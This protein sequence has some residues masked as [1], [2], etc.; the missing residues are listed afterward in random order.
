MQ[1]TLLLTLSLFPC[2]LLSCVVPVTASAQR[3][4]DKNVPLRILK[5]KDTLN[6]IAYKTTV[7]EHIKELETPAVIS[8]A[9]ETA[10]ALSTTKTMID[11]LT[12]TLDGVEGLHYGRLDEDEEKLN[13]KQIIINCLNYDESGDYSYYD[14]YTKIYPAY[15]YFYYATE[16]V[17]AD[18]P[19]LIEVLSAIQKRLEFITNPLIQ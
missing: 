7:K 11:V 8:D 12:L 10:K 17:K 6:L 16:D 19:Q 3:T 4:H 2:A 18:V 9:T 14:Y 5:E 1:K 15:D 13:D